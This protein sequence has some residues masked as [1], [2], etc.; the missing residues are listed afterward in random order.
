M[1]QPLANFKAEW[2]ST[3]GSDDLAEG[4]P[5]NRRFSRVISDVASGS[6][7]R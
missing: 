5:S 1:A 4:R 6:F 7:R 3:D 2:H